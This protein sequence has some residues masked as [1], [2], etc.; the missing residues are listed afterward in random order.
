M[1]AVGVSGLVNSWPR[2]RQWRRAFSVSR[3][4]RGL[5]LH[6][7]AH[8]AVGIWGLAVFL[9]V[10]FAG[11]YLAFPETVRS[12]VDLVLPA[13]DLRAAAVVVQVEPVAGAEPLGIDGAIE[14]ARSTMPGTEVGFA[15]LP[16]RPDQPFR[17]ALLRAEQDR[18][19]PPITVLVDPWSRRVVE[20]LDPRQFSAAE[21]VLAWQ[22]AI[23]AGQ[24]LGWAWKIMV[25]LSGLLPLFFVVTGVT[26]WWLK[27]GHRA[28]A[29]ASARDL[30]LDHVDTARRAGE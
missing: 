11:V 16:T 23:H 30:V 21:R 2:R 1:L 17:I 22:H 28:S 7:E 9:T 15:F 26:M 24:G 13:R 4:A 10:T 18:H 8:G 5:R 12:A 20:V 3:Q 6:R 19:A 14:L 27:R 29:P 25:F